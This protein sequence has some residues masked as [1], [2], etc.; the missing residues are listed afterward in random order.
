MLRLIVTAALAATSIGWV[1]PANAQTAPRPSVTM[2][3]Q[4]TRPPP[5]VQT[6][7]SGS[8]Q[9]TFNLFGVPTYITTPMAAPYSNSAYQNFGGQPGRSSDSLLM[10]GSGTP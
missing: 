4:S 6:P 10:Q 7:G 8:G 1:S 9:P 5:W 2:P 3:G